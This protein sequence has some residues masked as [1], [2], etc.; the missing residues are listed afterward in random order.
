MLELPIFVYRY[1]KKRIYCGP[2]YKSSLEEYLVV[3][4]SEYDRSDQKEVATHRSMVLAMHDENDDDS[5][6]RYLG[7]YDHT[8]Q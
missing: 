8:T 2:M 5:D 1:L 6:D 4:K 3:R 7:G